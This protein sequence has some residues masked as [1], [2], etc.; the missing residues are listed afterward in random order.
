MGEYEQ[1]EALAARALELG[2][3]SIS[4]VARIPRFSG[5]A[6]AQLG[7]ANEG[8]GLIREGIAASS[9]SGPLAIAYYPAL[10]A[11]AQ[12]RAGA[13]ADA[14]ETVEEALQSNPEELGYRPET[15]RVRGELRLKQGQAES[16]EA[17]FREAIALAQQDG[18]QSVGIARDDQSRA[19]AR[20]AGPPRRSADDA[21]RNLRLVHRGLRHRGLEGREITAG[22]TE[23]M[24]GFFRTSAS[25]GLMLKLEAI[26]HGE[27]R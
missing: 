11:A 7:R 23:V 14:M 10:L 27:A 3:T 2:A 18:R 20:K 8:I 15:I 22:R 19:I 9:S 26:S 1:A 4:A 13:V 5:L 17:E 21:R 24:S 16:A 25:T 12:H 6:R